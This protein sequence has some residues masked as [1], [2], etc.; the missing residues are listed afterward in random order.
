MDS[1]RVEELVAENARMDL[2]NKSNQEQISQLMTELETEREKSSG[3]GGA[4]G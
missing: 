4:A 1:A 3:S 2:E